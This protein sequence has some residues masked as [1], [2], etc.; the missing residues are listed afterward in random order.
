MDNTPSTREQLQP[1]Q[2]SRLAELENTINDNIE[3]FFKVGYALREIRD[4]RL[5][6]ADY[7]TFEEYCSDRWDL[8]RQIAHRQ[9]SAIET[10][11]YLKA[12]LPGFELEEQ[13]YYDSQ[14][15]EKI[16]LVTKVTPKGQK[17]FIKKLTKK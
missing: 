4:K 9:I 10:V 15:K 12:K 11:E 7:D 13:V 6:R 17:Y 16:S 8:G 3:G 1:D 5:Y 2:Q 14:G